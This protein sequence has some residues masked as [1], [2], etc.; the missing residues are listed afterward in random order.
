MLRQTWPH[1]FSSF[2][3]LFLTFFIVTTCVTPLNADD[4]VRALIVDGQNNHDWRTTTPLL[5]ACLEAT[6]RFQVDVATAPPQGKPAAEWDAFRPQF[7]QYQ[8]VISNYNGQSWPQPVQKSLEEFVAK[9]GGLVIV[10]AA[11]NAFSDWPEY[12]KM[13]GLGWR[14]AEFGSRVTVGKDGKTLILPKGEGPGAGHGSQHDY[15]IV[16]RDRQHPVMLGIPAEWMHVKDEL[17]HG[18]R[19]PAANMHILATA[20]S[21]GSTNGTEEHEP[22]IWWIPYG[23]G[24]VFTTLLGHGDYSMKCVGFQTT[25]GRGAEWV[26]TGKVTIPVPKNFPTATATVSVEGAK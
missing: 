7:D 23:K 20:F 26:A 19:G 25:F 18:Q 12:N 11:N 9:G 8:V 21:A 13:I 5:Q 10:H 6:G 16:T 4:K 14:G 3:W 15:T 22:L 17:Y 24:K 2:V 1:R